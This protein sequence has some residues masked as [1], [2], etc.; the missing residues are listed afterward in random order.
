MCIVYILLANGP[1][2]EI[3]LSKDKLI[4]LSIYVYYSISMIGKLLRP[5]T[6]DLYMD[7]S[8][9]LSLFDCRL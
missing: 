8:I 6:L 3:R 9:V 4:S 5:Q 1:Q 7:W 2:S